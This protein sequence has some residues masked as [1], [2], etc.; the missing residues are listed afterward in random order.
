MEILR[1]NSLDDLKRMS[2]NNETDNSTRKSGSNEKEHV[3]TYLTY[4]FRGNKISEY[5][6]DKTIEEIYQNGKHGMPVRCKEFYICFAELAEV[7]AEKIKTALENANPFLK[8]NYNWHKKF[9]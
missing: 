2:D 3:R 8:D 1:V 4:D 9:K 5:N 7:D 6:G